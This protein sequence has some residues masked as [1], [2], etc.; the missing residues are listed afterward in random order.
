MKGEG[1]QYPSSDI[2]APVILAS[3]WPLAKHFHFVR[4]QHPV[5][6]LMRL[7]HRKLL[8]VKKEKKKFDVK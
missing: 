5:R 2:I 8:P 7:I 1:G 6:P 4:H 3:F